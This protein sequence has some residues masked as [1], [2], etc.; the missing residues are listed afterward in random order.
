[1]SLLAIASGQLTLTN[2]T[3]RYREQAHSYRGFVV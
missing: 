3:H 2:L 1:M